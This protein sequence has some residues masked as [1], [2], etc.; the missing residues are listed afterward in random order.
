MMENVAHH[1]E[2]AADVGCISAQDWQKWAEGLIADCESPEGWVINLFC[3]NSLEELK[4]AIHEQLFCEQERHGEVI[5]VGN[6]KLGVLF[7][8][9]VHGRINLR[10]FLLRAGEVAEGGFTDIDPE[11]IYALLT[12]LESGNKDD[13]AQSCTWSELHGYSKKAENFDIVNFSNNCKTRS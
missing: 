10:E 11:E 9:H 1:L 6:F 2:A 12:E 7:L 4:S 3:A 5:S 8:M 13:I